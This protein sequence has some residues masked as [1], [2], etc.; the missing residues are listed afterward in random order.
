MFVLQTLVQMI[1]DHI[2]K[3]LKRLH[4]EVKG[5]VYINQYFNRIKY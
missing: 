3:L 2:T 1:Q 4:K 5:S